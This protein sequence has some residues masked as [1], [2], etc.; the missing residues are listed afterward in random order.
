[1]LFSSLVKLLLANAGTLRDD[2][3][4]LFVSVCSSVCRLQR[5]HKNAVFVKTKAI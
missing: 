4:R 1:M 5:V 3:V 2:A